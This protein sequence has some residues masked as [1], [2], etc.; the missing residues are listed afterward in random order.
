MKL[1]FSGNAL[2]SPSFCSL[3]IIHWAVLQTTFEFM[4]AYNQE[5]DVY[6]PT[7]YAVAVPVKEAEPEIVVVP[8]YVSAPPEDQLPD[9]SLPEKLSQ[10]NVPLQKQAQNVTE[11]TKDMKEQEKAEEK[12][13]SC[14]TFEA[15]DSMTSQVSQLFSSITGT[16]NNLNKNLNQ[17]QRS[18]QN[19]WTSMIKAFETLSKN[20]SSILNLFK[21]C[22]GK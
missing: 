22:R 11:A 12:D 4:G 14:N 21:G 8:I 15:F 9:A 13:A 6:V 16:V 3:L 18:L 19:D 17:N 20:L 2:A 7:V 10:T 1:K 5:P